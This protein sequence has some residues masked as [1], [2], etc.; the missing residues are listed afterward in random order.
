MVID[1]MAKV[2]QRVLSINTLFGIR[3]DNDS[4]FDKAI[5]W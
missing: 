5:Y 1:A 2:G 4:L 3:N